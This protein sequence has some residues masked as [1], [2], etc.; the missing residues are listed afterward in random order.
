MICTTANVYHRSV[1][2]ITMAISYVT[3]LF[4]RTHKE[5]RK[6]TIK[7]YK[8]LDLH[9][10]NLFNW[11]YTWP[12]GNHKIE[13]KELKKEISMLVLLIWVLFQSTVSFDSSVF[14]CIER[15]CGFRPDKP[16]SNW[17]FFVF[18]FRL[19]ILEYKRST[20]VLWA[21][22]QKGICD[23]WRTRIKIQR[24]SLRIVEKDLRIMCWQALWLVGGSKILDEKWCQ[25][26]HDFVWTFFM[27]AMQYHIYVSNCKLSVLKKEIRSETEVFLR[28]WL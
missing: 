15:K 27:Y 9:L 11:E 16:L 25:L 4:L 2:F 22:I 5:L 18:S 3:L 23:A 26:G 10:N 21:L 13:E 12:I 24:G 14:L 20:Y 19:K 8:S 28:V 7:I 17:I 1:Y 6:I